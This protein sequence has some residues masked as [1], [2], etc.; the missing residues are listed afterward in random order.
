[1]TAIPP[2]WRALQTYVDTIDDNMYGERVQLIPWQGG[3]RVT[4][5]GSQDPKRAVLNT[6]G[7]YVTPGARAG[8]EGGTIASGLA[9]NMQT[10]REWVSIQENNL[11]DPAL[12]VM[13]DRVFLPDQLPNQQWHSIEKIEPSATKRYNVI[14]IRLQDTTPLT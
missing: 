13:Y 12:W 5:T 6:I 8:G 4:D 14:L 9:T 7:I 11:G 1:M 2:I 10:S 3:Q